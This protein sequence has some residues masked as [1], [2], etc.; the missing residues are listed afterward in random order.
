MDSALGEAFYHSRQ[1]D[2]TITYNKLSLVH[3]PTYAVALINL[4]RAY[5]Q[6]GMTA[7]ALATYQ[8]ILAVVPD[9][10]GLLALVAHANAVS[11]KSALARAA[12]AHLEQMRATKYVPAVYIALVYVGLGEKDK[13]F[14]WLDRAYDERCEYLVY[15]PTEP[16]ADPLRS[17]TRFS[18]LIGRLGLTIPKPIK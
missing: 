14:Q 9:D 16:M 11:G 13:A 12:L 17:D 10:P 2:N 1:F 6:K 5:E 15:L 18:H 8:T 7:Q 4:G 3:D